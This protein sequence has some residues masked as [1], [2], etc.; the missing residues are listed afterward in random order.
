MSKPE[1]IREAIQKAE[2]LQADARALNAQAQAIL[3]A[4]ASEESGIAPGDLVEFAHGHQLRRA[5]VESVTGALRHSVR[6]GSIVEFTVIATTLPKDG[7]AGVRLA[8][9]PY[10]RRGMKKV[11]AANA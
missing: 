7:S 4:V 3:D 6:D 1:H 8:F 5:C 2:Q 10:Y 9:S 11:E